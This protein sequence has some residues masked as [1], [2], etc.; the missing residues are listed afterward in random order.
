MDVL[1]KKLYYDYSTTNESFLKLHTKLKNEG[2]K[3]NAFFLILFDRDLIGINPY[4]ENLNED[5][6]RKIYNECKNNF[7][8]FIREVV[9]IPVCNEV[10]PF[11]LNK[12]NLSIFFNMIKSNNIIAEGIRSGSYKTISISARLIWE[13]IFNK[14]TAS[15]M[16]ISNEDI[17]QTILRMD[18]ILNQLPQY[19]TPSEFTDKYNNKLLLYMK[20]LKSNYKYNY[21]KYTS[22]VEAYNVGRQLTSERIWFDNFAFIEYNDILLNTCTP[23]NA[24]VK[25]NAISNNKPAGIILSSTIEDLD[26][27]RGIFYKDIKDLAVRFTDIMYDM[28]ENELINYIKNNSFNEFVY[29]KYDYNELDISENE[30]QEFCKMLQNDPEAIRKELLLEYKEEVK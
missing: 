28:N 25:S 22:R 24:K 18:I 4:D 17:R 20:D 8:Y 10:I 3:N 1:R 16:D 14:T 15:F 30:Y 27:Y 2:V 5:I 11:K 26:V 29:I 7:W 6:K 21:L 12:L 23:S 19:I 9:R 13:I